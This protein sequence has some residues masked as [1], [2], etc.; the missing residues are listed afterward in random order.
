MNKKGKKRLGIVFLLISFLLIGVGVY[1]SIF[2]V[3]NVMLKMIVTEFETLYISNI[4]ENEKFKNITNGFVEIADN[5]QTQKFEFDSTIYSDQ[6]NS[7][8]LFEGGVS[9]L[10]TDLASAKIFINQNKLY[11]K[12]SD[13]DPLQYI[14]FVDD[15]DSMFPAS[16]LEE[17]ENI[18]KKEIVEN[19]PD[20]NFYKTKENVT[21]NQNNLETEKY[22]MKVTTLDFYNII[23]NVFSEIR[24]N[25]NIKKIN[26]SITKFFTEEKTTD[27]KFLQELKTDML[28][29]NGE[30]SNETLFEYRIYSLKDKIVKHELKMDDVVYIFGKYEK[31]TDIFDYELIIKEKNTSVVTMSIIGSKNSSKIDAMLAGV[32]IEGENVLNETK[33]TLTL[34]AFADSSK[35]LEIINFSCEKLIENNKKESSS[36]IKLKVNF[37]V[38][39]Y[40]NLSLSNSYIK[41]EEV[42]VFDVTGATKFDLGGQLSTIP[43]PINVVTSSVA[44]IAILALVPT[45]TSFSLMKNA[46]NISQNI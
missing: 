8:A 14:E 45:V 28:G 22:E 12:L 24:S 13:K 11:F 15:K 34:K 38:N 27:D 43:L 36:T 42:P 29:K 32:I 10:G 1:L 4:K 16:E 5:G 41:N 46:K 19:L 30:N 17:I 35:S 23:S 7:K 44:P 6:Q 33:E 26:E 39:N 40:F 20:K 25:K 18:L 31:E 21:V 9:L 37:D 2:S 3:K